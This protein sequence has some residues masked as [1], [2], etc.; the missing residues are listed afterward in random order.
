MSRAGYSED[1]DDDPWSMIRWRGAVTSAMNGRRGQA[2]LREL[3]AALDAL[4][5]KKLVAD[6]LKDNGCY[7]ALGAVGRARGL[8]LERLDP[9]DWSGLSGTFGIA[10]ALVR[11]IMGENDGDI[12]Y[13]IHNETPE[14]RFARIRKWVERCIIKEPT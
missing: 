1:G 3:L 4:P 14:E 6:E 7:C 5:E 9:Y 12:Y 8:D 11:E 2:F 10:E 13:G